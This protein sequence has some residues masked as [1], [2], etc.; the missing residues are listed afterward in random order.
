MQRA[1][2]YRG[3][4]QNYS[5]FLEYEGACWRWRRDPDDSWCFIDEEGEL[6]RRLHPVIGPW[7]QFSL[8]NLSARFTVADQI[9]QRK[10]YNYDFSIPG[11]TVPGKCTRQS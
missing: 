5:H 3:P 6:Q 8:S 11:T 2:V 10:N 4:V 7:K 9:A 1:V